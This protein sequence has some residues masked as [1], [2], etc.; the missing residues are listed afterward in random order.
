[1]GFQYGDISICIEY[2]ISFLV[3]TKLRMINTHLCRAFM[4]PKQPVQKGIG[5]SEDIWSSD[6][7]QNLVSYFFIL[8]EHHI[9][10]LSL[11]QFRS[12]IKLGLNTFIL[13]QGLAHALLYW[14][15]QRLRKHINIQCFR[16]F[17]NREG[18]AF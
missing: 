4:L 6:P 11:R 2:F 14:N 15:T 3:K 5:D 8:A 9:S 17:Y 10:S 12:E 7:D 16:D 1:M 13:F 18:R